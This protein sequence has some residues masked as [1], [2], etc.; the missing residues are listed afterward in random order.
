V[1]IKITWAYRTIKVNF[2]AHGAEEEFD[3]FPDAKSSTTMTEDQ[4]QDDLRAR[5]DMDAPVVT[6]TK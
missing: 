4:R 3:Y 2:A 5:M 1:E 6:E